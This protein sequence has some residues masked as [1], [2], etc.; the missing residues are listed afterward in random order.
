ME[1]QPRKKRILIAM[2]EVGGCHASIAEAIKGSM[3]IL[4]PN[5]FD[6][7]VV[8]LPHASGAWQMDRFIKRL[9]H[10]ALARPVLTARVNGWLEDVKKPARS[11]AMVQVF[12]REFLRKGMRLVKDYQPDLVITTHF[13]CTSVAV[14]ARQRQHAT[15]RV[16]EH[17]SDPFQ[18][19]NLW[20]NS[21][22]DEVVVCSPEVRSQLTELGQSADSLA[23]LPFPIHPRFFTPLGS[24]EDL[25]E[26]LGLDPSRPTIL[27]SSGGEGIGNMDRYLRE[28]YLSDLPVNLIAVCGRNERLLRD[29][30]LLAL[31]PSRV[32]FVPLGFV[33]NMNELAEAA[34]VGL[35]KAGPSTLLEMLSKGCPVMITQVAAKVE[36][37]NL[38]FVTENGLGWDVRESTAFSKLLEELFAPGFLGEVRARIQE[39]AYVREMPSAAFRVARHLI[40]ENW[41]DS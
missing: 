37:G 25:L 15:F 24:R 34:D 11:N 9:W 6:I 12:F 41:M 22:V 23:V 21:M 35:V 38:R 26:S 29:L 18:A 27:A 36:E 5:R 10:E 3:E 8:D 16:V 30:R 39:N 20:V 40:P 13:F 14:L 31:R 1:E 17:V 7:R 33:N 4:H 19:H 32:R 28:I 2:I